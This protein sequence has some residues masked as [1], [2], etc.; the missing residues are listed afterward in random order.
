MVAV[1]ATAALPAIFGL[2]LAVMVGVRELI[3][4]FGD[5][6]MLCASAAPAGINAT[7]VPSSAAAAVHVTIRRLALTPFTG[8]S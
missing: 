3:L 1:F 6:M 8:I 2:I 7:A 4:R 5:R